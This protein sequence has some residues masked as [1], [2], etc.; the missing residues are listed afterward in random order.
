MKRIILMLLLFF[1]HKQIIVA[2]T[3]TSTLTQL[4]TD[5]MSGETRSSFNWQT[6]LLF[7]PLGTNSSHQKANCE[8]SYSVGIH[9]MT[10]EACI[11]FTSKDCKTILVDGSCTGEVGGSGGGTGTAGGTAGTSTSTSGTTGNTGNTGGTVIIYVP[12]PPVVFFPSEPPISS[13][14][15]NSPSEFGGSSNSGGETPPSNFMPTK[16]PIKPIKV[17]EDDDSTRI[18][19]IDTTRKPPKKFIDFVQSKQYDSAWAY[20]INTY[21]FDTTNSV[22]NII[23]DS[24]RTFV[25]TTGKLG[26]DSLQTVNITTNIFEAAASEDLDWAQFI[27]G[28]GHEFEHVKQ[29]SG[30][31]PIANHDEREFLAYVYTLAN[32]TLPPLTNEDKEFFKKKLTK[33]YNNLSPTLQ[34]QYQSLYQTTLKL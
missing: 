21:N 15:H 19:A 2:Q 5:K 29:K 30:A 18:F 7:T 31:N 10:G 26:K 34:S 17:L 3:V 8:E 23:K 33:Y 27:R 12:S 22:V 9:P 16:E 25:T 11:Y 32:T 6:M 4:T 13:Y 28:I 1:A 14:G 20:I 24:I